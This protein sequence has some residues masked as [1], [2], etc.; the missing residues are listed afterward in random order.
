MTFL[1]NTL[2]N[3]WNELALG[4][5]SAKHPFHQFVFTNVK[6]DS[7]ESR[8]VVLRNVSEATRIIEF[9]TDNRSPKYSDLITNNNI[10]ALFY[11]HIRK[12]QLRFNGKANILKDETEKLTIWNKLTRESKICYMGDFKP[13]TNLNIYKPNIPSKKITELSN[14]EYLSGFKNFARIQISILKLDWLLLHSNGHKRIK[15]EWI[16]GKQFENWIAT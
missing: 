14:D 1:K 5:R 11:D 4:T 7:P 8:T 16:N 3:E 9:N 13:S 2:S 12:V 10:S 15:Y 6:N